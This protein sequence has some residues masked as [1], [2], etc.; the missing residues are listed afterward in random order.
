M[1]KGVK[2]SKIQLF[3]LII[4]FLYSNTVII[5]P[6]KGALQDIWIA[7]IL[8]LAGGFALLSVYLGIAKLNPYKTLIQIL[9]DTFG[10]IAGIII[11]IAYIWYFI[12]IS[13]LVL[14]DFGEYMIT[15]TF[16]ETPIAFVM[17]ALSLIIAI[18]LKKGFEVV[19]RTNELMMLVLPLFVL[20]LIVASAERY[21]FK[22]LLPVLENG[23]VF[24]LKPAFCNLTFPFGELVVF[25]MIFPYL[26]KQE[27]LL[28][29][30]YFALGVGGFLIFMSI[31]KD[32]LVLGSDMII[33]THFPSNI[34]AELIPSIN[35]EPL[36]TANM[37][38]GGGVKVVICIYAAI[39]GI[40]ELFNLNN[41]RILVIPV[42]SFVLIL[43]IWLFDN[44]FDTLRW[45][46]EVWPY[47]SIP[48][49]IV[50][51]LLI[52]AISLVKH[53]IE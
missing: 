23:F 7:Y 11:S 45:G 48:F 39:A 16:P 31:I 24:V 19:A 50:I 9:I 30:S 4:G 20:F 53:R 17:G 3:L 22:N 8:A 13:A 44:I 21:D 15:T 36:I 49:Q 37:M 42:S 2:I 33:R 46:G 26:N 10:K 35:P 27:K 40:S 43:S 25:L 29:T 5:N 12:H 38:I 14:R 32:F 52:F 47:Y 34:S 18:A 28:K 1:V 6:V 51:P 41:L